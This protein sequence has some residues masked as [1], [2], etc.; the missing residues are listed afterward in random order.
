MEL[1]KELIGANLSEEVAEQQFSGEI[2]KLDS[3][4][5]WPVSVTRGESS[6]GDQGDLPVDPREELQPSRLHKVNQPM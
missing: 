3:A 6:M 5:E 2:A 1:D 4:I